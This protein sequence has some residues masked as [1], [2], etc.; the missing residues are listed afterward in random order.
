PGQS[1]SLDGLSVPFGCLGAKKGAPVQQ[2]FAALLRV[3]DGT[4]TLNAPGFLRPDAD[5][6]VVFVAS[7]DDCSAA[8]ATPPSSTYQCARAGLACDQELPETLSTE[9]PQQLTSCSSREDDQLINVDHVMEALQRPKDF[10]GQVSVVL[11]AA[12]PAPFRIGAG[13]ATPS[14]P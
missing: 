5:L 2:P 1:S 9:T 3:L 11:I 8:M 10:Q 6:L 14:A 13:N 12:P 4:Q 7:Q